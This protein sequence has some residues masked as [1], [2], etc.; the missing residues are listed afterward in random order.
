MVYYSGHGVEK[1]KESY[2]IPIDALI[3]QD[4]DIPIDGVAPAGWLVLLEK[5]NAKIVLVVLDACRDNPFIIRSRGGVKGLTRVHGDDAEG[6]LVAYATRNGEPADDG[7][8]SNSP[9]A[10]AL[11]RQLKRTDQ[12]IRLAFEKIGDEVRAATRNKQKPITYGD[13]KSTVYL[14]PIKPDDGMEQ[15]AWE[16]C[17]TSLT[18]KPC[19]G[20]IAHYPDGRFLALVQSR[21]AD[22]VELERL[23][24]VPTP[25]KPAIYENGNYLGKGREQWEYDRG[26]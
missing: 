17:K 13:L 22:L 20:Y 12:P 23:R 2:L 1:E 21:L 3:K 16:I 6:I 14:T 24:V 26:S 15:Q 4:S 18:S 10:L 11:A 8:G 7:D 25:S 5:A 9:Y 19:D